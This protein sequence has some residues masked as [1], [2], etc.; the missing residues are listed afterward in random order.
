M[1]VM[2][3]LAAVV[4]KQQVA[5]WNDRRDEG[6]PRAK[7]KPEPRREEREDERDLRADLAAQEDAQ[8]AERVEDERARD[9]Q[10]VAPKIQVAAEVLVRRAARERRDDDFERDDEPGGARDRDERAQPPTPLREE[11]QAEPDGDE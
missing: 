1:V 6:R 4:G 7:R 10:L 2:G 9:L 5:E 8:D 11:R 3:V